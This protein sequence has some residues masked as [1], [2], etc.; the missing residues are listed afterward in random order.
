[1]YWILTTYKAQEW[2]LENPHVSSQVCALK[3]VLFFFK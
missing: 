3:D 1:M 2:G